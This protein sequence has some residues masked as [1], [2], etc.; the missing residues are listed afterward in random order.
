MYVSP[1]DLL[2]I[3]LD[4]LMNLDEKGIIRLEKRLKLQKHQR[5]LGNYNPQQTYEL[6]YQLKDK[7]KRKIHSFC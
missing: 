4:E 2:D 1:V 5:K 7:E 6:L 3:S